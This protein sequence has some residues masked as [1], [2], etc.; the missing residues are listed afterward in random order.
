MIV[1]ILTIIPKKGSAVKGTLDFLIS[2]L[3]LTVTSASY[4]AGDKEKKL[5]E[6]AQAGYVKIK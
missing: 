2:P 1:T 5:K 4:I 6:Q 3:F